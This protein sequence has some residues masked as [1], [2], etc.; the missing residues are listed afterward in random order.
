MGA[1]HHHHGHNHGHGHR[2]D[3][4][5][6]HAPANFDRAFAIGIGL[7]LAFVAVEAT[8]GLISG[9]LALLADAGHNL[10]DVLGLVLAWAAAWAGRRRP[11]GRY[12]YGFR[13]ASILASLANAVLLLVAVGVI[14]AEAVG[15]FSE[16][17]PVETGTVMIV[18][19]IG[20]LINAATA[21][22]FF[23]GRKSD[24]NIRGAYLHMAADAAVSAGVVIAAFAMQ[25]T[26]MLWIDPAVSL[27]VAVV[28]TIGTWGLLSGSVALALDAVPEHI[29]RHEVEAYLAALPGVSAITDL[30]IWAMSTTEVAL[31]AHLVRPGADVDDAFIL[32]AREELGAKFGIGHVTLQVENGDGAKGGCSA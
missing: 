14:V 31:T 21:W 10:S 15:R 28:I 19:G 30:H 20:I 3:H 32:D 18:A 4:G 11:T 5:H 27:I 8:Y 13:R 29:E 2:H 24:L 7:N 25:A 23:S 16:P 9:S 6:A 22:F 1:G 26:G 17:R 12:T